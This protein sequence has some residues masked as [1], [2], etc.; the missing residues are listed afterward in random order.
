M[1]RPMID[2]GARRSTLNN[3]LIMSNEKTSVFVGDVRYSEGSLLQRFVNPKIKRVRYSE[4]P[5]ILK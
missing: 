3:A 4:C 1:T 5:L 2:K